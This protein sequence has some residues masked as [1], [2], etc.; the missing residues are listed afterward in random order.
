MWKNCI[1]ALHFYNLCIILM[2]HL[3]TAK[4]IKNH[5]RMSRLKEPGKC[6][7]RATERSHFRKLRE[8]VHILCYFLISLQID[9][10]PPKKLVCVIFLFS[11]QSIWCE[12]IMNLLFS[13][14]FT[15]MFTRINC[16]RIN[17]W[18]TVCHSEHRPTR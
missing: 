9:D 2:S 6:Y 13:T 1:T 11:L 18:L 3:E 7:L 8:G 12:G 14:P 4:G 17:S 10:F 15:I 5:C 16:T